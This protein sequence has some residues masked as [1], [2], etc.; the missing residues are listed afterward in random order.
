MGMQPYKR[1]K[2]MRIRIM[3]SISNIV[4]RVIC[5]VGTIVILLLLIKWMTPWFQHMGDTLW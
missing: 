3:S 5:W 4:W 2:L 1:P